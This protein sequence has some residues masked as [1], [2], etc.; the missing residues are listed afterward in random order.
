MYGAKK[1]KSEKI[2]NFLHRH[3]HH[4][5]SNSSG[6]SAY[7]GNPN[8]MDAYNPKTSTPPLRP[9]TTS[10][11]TLNEPVLP[12]AK[13]SADYERY[14]TVRKMNMDRIKEFNTKS[15]SSSS[16]NNDNIYN[17]NLT[18]TPTFRN[19]VPQLEQDILKMVNY[20][21]PLPYSSSAYA[22]DM[23]PPPSAYA[24]PTPYVSNSLLINILKYN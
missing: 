21:T 14:M 17:L 15:S 6:G 7:H 11:A 2:R 4:K 18:N 3:G 23:R 24:S 16:Y 1:K 22:S 13:F 19:G 20:D 10:V 5:R 8:W 12:S 9:T